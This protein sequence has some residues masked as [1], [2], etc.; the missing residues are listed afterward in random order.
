MDNPKINREVFKEALQEALQDLYN[1]HILRRNPLR[2]LLTSGDTRPSKALGEL[3][4]QAIQALRPKNHVPTQANERRIYRILTYRYIEQLT[5]REVATE[6]SLSTRQLRRLEHAAISVLAD[7]LWRRYEFEHEPDAPPPAAERHKPETP[8]PNEA[9]ELAWIKAS[10]QPEIID[11][12]G[13]VN[14]V[15]ATL[16][17]LAE[18][19]HVDVSSNIDPDLPGIK[20]QRTMIQQAALSLLTAGINAAQGGS[21]HVVA[22]A[23]GT[24]VKLQVQ[25][26]RQ[27]AGPML[28]AEST[29]KLEMAQQMSAIFDGRLEIQ[30][31]GGDDLALSAALV[32]PSVEKVAVLVIDDNADV[33]QLFERY[34]SGTRY[35]FHGTR[36]P[37][38]AISLAETLSPQII[39]I[40]IMLPEI[41]GWE[42]L[43]RLRSHPQTQEARLVVCTILPQEELANALQAD[44][45]VRKP[46][47]R[48]RFLAA[49]NQQSDVRAGE[50][51]RE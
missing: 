25:A 43:G 40:D 49:L 9:E 11:P 15:I 6:L 33:L 5:Q 18:M 46:V 51:S 10:V 31:R 2:V 4:T 50:A 27:K 45:F 39:V 7:Y 26:K 23:Q 28:D 3:L 44:D 20:G 42:L 13:M 16:Q 37:N 48:E 1:P 30:S 17:P 47:N 14:T 22:T 41:D 36:D 35:E 34:L 8:F 12:T 38:K 29:E 24:E 21:V 32:V 19:K